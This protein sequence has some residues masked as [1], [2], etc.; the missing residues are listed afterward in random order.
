MSLSLN[1]TVADESGSGISGAY[2][3]VYREELGDFSEFWSESITKDDGSYSID[4]IPG[5][6]YDVGVYLTSELRGQNYTE[7]SILNVKV[8]KASE[9]DISGVDF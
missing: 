6:K 2:V 9:R 5:G 1:G 8:P 3:W 4:I 7:P